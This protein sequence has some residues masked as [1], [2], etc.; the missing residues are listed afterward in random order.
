MKTAPVKYYRVKVWIAFILLFACGA[1]VG[2]GISNWGR[3]VKNKSIQ[4]TVVE[5]KTDSF[6]ED[7]MVLTQCQAVERVLLN[8]LNGNEEDC[9]L[10]NR[11]L[12]VY[13]KLATYG[14]DENMDK[15]RHEIDNKNAILQVA[16]DG[17][18]EEYTNRMNPNART[19][20][21][22]ER[23]LTDRLPDDSVGQS[24]SGRIDRAK[25]Y[26][27]MAER[28]CPENSAK[29]TELAKQELEIARAIKDDDFSE[30]DTIEIV[31]TYKRIKMQKDAEE[32]F[33]KVK[34]MTNPAI[35]F[36]MQIEKI[37]NE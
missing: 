9:Y 19:C 23:D 33:D 24:A 15:Y 28:G 16:C 17:Y 6:R 35:D 21:K 1:M 29:Y 36:I 20:E 32:I 13:K 25:I 27:V 10:I 31:E 30:D 7:D 3:S 8:R 14:C 34:K 26:A 22:I 5:Q 4:K 18:F 11:D 12:D 2:V 37:I